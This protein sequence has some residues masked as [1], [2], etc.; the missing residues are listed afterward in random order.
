MLPED[1]LDA[2]RDLKLKGQA[3]LYAL[4]LGGLFFLFRPLTYREHN[5]VA[6]LEVKVDS[7]TLT[8]VINELGV[9][10]WPEPMDTWGN[11]CKPGYPDT[12]AQSIQD[13]SGYGDPKGFL[14][15][16]SDART[17]LNEVSNLITLF[18]CSAFKSILPDDVEGMTLSQQAK[19]LALAEQILG[20]PLDLD[21]MLG[22]QITDKPG[23]PD[24]PVPPGMETTDI[25]SMLSPDA[26]GLEIPNLDSI[27][28]GN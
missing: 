12:L 15:T 16:V 24:I 23:A 6:E 4:E 21:A 25:D 5:T 7:D 11:T 13:V 22:E 28:K 27:L 8:D 20:N 19:H 17:S 9:V 18:I 1:V 26:P 10:Y 14:D 3:E 2:Y